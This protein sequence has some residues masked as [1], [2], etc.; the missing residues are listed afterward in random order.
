MKMEEILIWHFKD[1]R[2]SQNVKSIAPIPPHPSRQGRSP[3]PMLKLAQQ[4]NT[5]P[6]F[7]SL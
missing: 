2:T 4:T 6:K 3:F 1:L 5:K 7:R